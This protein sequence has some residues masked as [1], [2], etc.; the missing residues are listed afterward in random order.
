LREVRILLLCGALLLAAPA[1]AVAARP[2]LGV[3]DVATGHRVAV[4]RGTAGSE[5]WTSVRWTPDGSALVA[6]RLER[7]GLVV[8][9]YAIAGGTR[10]LRDLGDA[11]DGVL[12]WDGTLV[13]ALYDAGNGIPGGR[14]GV[15]VRDVA[16]GRVRFR[17]PQ[18]AEGDDLYEN[19]LEVAWSRDGSR[20]AYLAEER[21]GRTLRIVDAGSGRVLR[22]VDAD[23]LYLGPEPFSP[24]GDRMAYAVG[25]YEHLALL[26]VGSGKVRRRAESQIFP[27]AWAPAGERLAGDA[28]GGV[29]VSDEQ[30]RFG[31]P[32]A[33]PEEE[34]VELIRWSPDGTRLALLIQEFRHDRSKLA[35]MPVSPAPGPAR[36][37][38]PYRASG[39]GGIQWSPDSRRIAYSG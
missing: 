32:Q 30:Q 17:L 38:I 36:I 35:V 25:D 15:A 12:N 37:V 10:K 16:T 21:R 31:P 28:Q 22:R 27:V 24:S 29:V 1:S 5:G 26:D 34:A 6:V 9:R 19:G 39:L 4:V 13:A 3:V 33:M 14:G 8:R 18:Y 20:L 7:R 11:L 2:T 23:N